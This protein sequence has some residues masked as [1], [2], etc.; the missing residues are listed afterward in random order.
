VINGP[1][2]LIMYGG[3]VA[4]GIIL[5]FAIEMFMRGSIN[6]GARIFGFLAAFSGNMAF[7]MIVNITTMYQ[8]G[9]MV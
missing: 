1:A 8:S 2:A 5:P 3:V 7:F 4:L 9:N 6:I